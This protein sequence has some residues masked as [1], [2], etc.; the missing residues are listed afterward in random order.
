MDEAESF[1]NRRL[2]LA[3]D[4][5]DRVRLMLHVRFG[6][7]KQL[8]I[9]IIDITDKIVHFKF[10]VFCQVHKVD[11]RKKKNKPNSQRT[12]LCAKLKC[13]NSYNSSAT[14]DSCRIYMTNLKQ[15]Y[16]D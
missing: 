1:G 14:T 11:L 2:T 15:H 13:Y 3:F 5:F 12:F 16:Y 10:I 4:V 8:L 7:A 9:H 6:S